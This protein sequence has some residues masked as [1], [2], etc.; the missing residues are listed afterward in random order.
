MSN[1]RNEKLHPFQGHCQYERDRPVLS[2]I[3]DNQSI[4]G[5]AASLVLVAFIEPPMKTVD[6]R[7]SFAEQ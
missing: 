7:Q 5:E 6:G 3:I 2:P 1:G 4:D